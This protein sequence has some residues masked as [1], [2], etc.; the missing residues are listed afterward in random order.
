MSRALRS[1]HQVWHGGSQ[2]GKGPPADSWLSFQ[3]VQVV[4]RRVWQ[5]QEF[6][7]VEFDHP[8]QQPR[9]PVLSSEGVPSSSNQ[10]AC[11]PKEGVMFQQ[12]F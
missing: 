6:L 10:P 9:L 11:Q 7:G 1:G 12:G 2:W 5:A 4:T 3:C 8:M